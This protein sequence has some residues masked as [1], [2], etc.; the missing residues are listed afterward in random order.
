MIGKDWYKNHTV[1]LTA[2][3][4]LSCE[5][6]LDVAWLAPPEDYDHSALGLENICIS[7]FHGL[8]RTEVDNLYRSSRVVL[9]CSL[10]EG[11]GYPV[12]EALSAGCS[13]V[14]SKAVAVNFPRLELIDQVRIVRNERD[15]LEIGVE[16]KALLSTFRPRKVS[17]TFMR[18]YS[19]DEFANNLMS[20]YLHIDEVLAHGGDDTWVG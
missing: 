5:R 18:A 7:G 6:H 17:E 3:A 1:H 11:F 19:P 8:T 16:I 2:L 15:F 9:F 14:T 12:I 13:L 10:T 20:A 4:E